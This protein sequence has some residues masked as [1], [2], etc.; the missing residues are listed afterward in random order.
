MISK[1]IDNPKRENGKHIT[2]LKTV[3]NYKSKNHVRTSG[4]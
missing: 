4:Y 2:S 3:R 1:Y